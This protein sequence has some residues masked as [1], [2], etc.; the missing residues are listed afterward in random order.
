MTAKDIQTGAL[1]G[2]LILFVAGDS[3]RSRRARANLMPALA[4]AGIAADRPREVDLLAKPQEAF[5][6]GLFAS[7]ALVLTDAGGA[8]QS[9][10]YGDLSD[11]PALQRFLAEVQALAGTFGA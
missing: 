4:D 2:R 8:P 9:I 5:R 10:L 11:E 6:H 1:G 3:P 7:P